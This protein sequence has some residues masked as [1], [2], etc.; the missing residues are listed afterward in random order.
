M[1]KPIRLLLVDDHAIVRHGLSLLLS[2]SREFVVAAEAGGVQEALAR[3]KKRAPDAAIIDLSM[4]DGS[5]LDLIREIKKLHP[6]LPC[7]VLSMHDELEYADR[8]LRA[9]A[10]GYVMKE[11]ADEVIVEALRAVMR[12][13]VY[14]SPDV[15]A[16]MLQQVANE[17]TADESEK[18]IASLTDREKEIFRSLGEGLTTKKIAEHFGLSARTVEV[19]RSSIKRKLMCEDGAQLLREAVRWVEATKES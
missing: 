13:E 3:V 4:K 9:G 1:A 16:R 12:G 6:D 8:A 7:L 5:G 15:A 11:N 18:G 10:R 17:S 14:A 2:K 19:H